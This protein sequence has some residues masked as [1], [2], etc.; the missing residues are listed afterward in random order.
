MLIA[1]FPS[2]VAT[3]SVPS[4]THAIVG[5]L[6]LDIY[7]LSLSSSRNSDGMLTAL[8]SRIP[9]R[10]IV[11]LEEPR[12]RV[13]AERHPRPGLH[14]TPG[15]DQNEPRYI[16]EP[17]EPRREPERRERALALA[18]AQRAG[19]QNIVPLAHSAKPLDAAELAFP[20]KE[21]ADGC[22]DEFSV[23]ALQGYI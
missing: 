15:G 17:P 18:P 12:R 19:R 2:S 3:C 1:A 22:P 23:A 14:G 7:T 21:F 16:T 10:G 6:M 20:A 13:H 5:E 4:L 8:M 11:F 9:A